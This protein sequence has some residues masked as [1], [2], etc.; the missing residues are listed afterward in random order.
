MDQYKIECEEC[1]SESHVFAYEQP[2]FCPMCGRRVEA[3]YLE[4]D[5]DDVESQLKAVLDF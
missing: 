2:E 1:E 4:H 5:L 3:E